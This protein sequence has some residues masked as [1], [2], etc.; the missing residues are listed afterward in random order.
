MSEI[1]SG[2]KGDTGADGATG[3]AGPIGPQGAVGERYN[4]DRILNRPKVG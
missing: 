1:I 4:T 2:P 3:P